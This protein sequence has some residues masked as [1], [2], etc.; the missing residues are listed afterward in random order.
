MN[1]WLDNSA[2]NPQGIG[3]FNPSGG[4]SGFGNNN[5]Q[6][7][8][9]HYQIFE[10]S[11]E[12]G[13]DAFPMGPNSSILL[14][15]I[16]GPIVWLVRTDSAGYKYMKVPYNVTPHQTTPPVDLNNLEQRIKTLEDLLANGKQQSNTKQS[17]KQQ[18]TTTESSAN[19]TN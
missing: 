8:L 7:P 18:S 4:R 15:D 19:T 6:P 1:N 11:G 12:N 2:V 5:F 16:T 9:P 17:R 3:N 13:V 14:A 10:V